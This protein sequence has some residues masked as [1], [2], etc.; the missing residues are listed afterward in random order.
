MKRKRSKLNNRIVSC[1]IL[2]AAIICIAICISG[3]YQYR[4]SIYSTF[5]NFGYQMGEVALSY[6]DGDTVTD[7]LSGK[8]PDKQYERMTDSLYHL[9]HN[10]NIA[11]IYVCVP[12]KEE[13]TLVNIYDT[14]IEDAENPEIYALGV[15]DRIVGNPSAVIETFETGIRPN[16]Y[17]IRKSVFGYNTSA[18][19][20]IKNSS[21]GE[22]VALLFVDIPVLNIEQNLRTYLISTVAITVLIVAASITLIQ[23][24]LQKLVVKP[25]KT[26][27]SEAAEFIRSENVISKKLGRIRT[28]DE[29]ETLA[30]SILQMEKDIN[31]YIDNLTA[32]TAEKERIGAELTVA[33]QIQAS[34]LPCIFPAFPEREEFDIY[35]SMTPAKE[36]GGDFYDFF[37]VDDDHLALVIADVSGKGVPAALFMVISKTL[38]K[39]QALIGHSP[40]EILEK[41]NNQLCENNEAEMF[42]TVWLGILEISTGKLTCANAG[43]EYPAIKR[44]TGAFELYKDKHGFV[45]AGMENV[46]YHEYEIELNKGDMLFVYTDGVAEATDINNTLYDINRMITALNKNT[47]AKPEQ[48]INNVLED[49]NAFVGEAEQFDDITMLA[50]TYG[51]RKPRDVIMKE[52]TVEAK[53]ENIER[54]TD[55][56]NQ[57]L[58]KCDCPKK[59]LRQIDVAIDELFGNIAHYAYNSDT[60]L[61]TVQVE[62]WQEPLEVVIT[63]ID[64]GISYNPLAKDDP[65]VTLSAKEREPGGLGIYMVKKSMDEVFYEYKDGQNILKIRK[66]LVK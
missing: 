66:R 53:I 42:V 23:M 44:A 35:A 47:N 28:N 22:I 49:I 31:N 52:L 10:S 9:Y 16:D 60:G 17:F 48:L 64:S 65:D 51:G 57:E 20:P 25:L 54:V 36:V 41:V 59:F 21:R 27:I 33:T 55:F 50:V 56:V 58:L 13:M 4:D 45:L 30:E 63:F 37:L 24:M 18:V 2:M 26:I 46:K 11:G 32:V 62:M 3:Y 34:M 29:I 14:R 8:E 7:Y 38:L 12:N 19:L 6:I 5:N 40:R 43:H 15:A 1:C 61:A 39:N